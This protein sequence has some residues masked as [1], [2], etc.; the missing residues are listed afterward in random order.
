MPS[1]VDRKFKGRSNLRKGKGDRRVLLQL[2][3]RD[4]RKCWLCGLPT[5]LFLVSHD[6]SASIDHVVRRV[7]GG[8]HGNGNLKVAHRRCNQYRHQ[9]SGGHSDHKN[10]IP[11]WEEQR[12]FLREKY[13]AEIGEAILQDKQ[14][15]MKPS[16]ADYLHAYEGEIRK[17]GKRAEAQKKKKGKL[18]PAHVLW[19]E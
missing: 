9:G 4:G 1:L 3:H 16:D 11:F 12:R 7:D 2:I 10:D 18:I 17:R 14:G 5:S 15:V 8:H 6:L 19:P 13:G